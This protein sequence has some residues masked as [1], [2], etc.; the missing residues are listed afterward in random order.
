MAERN[1]VQVG[2]GSPEY[3]AFKLML[4]VAMVEGGLKD[5]KGILDTYAECLQ[6]TNGYRDISRR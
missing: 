5:R 4:E 3:I 1:P 6:T 2:E